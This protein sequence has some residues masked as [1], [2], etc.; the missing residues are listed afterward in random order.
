VKIVAWNLNH[1]AARRRIPTWVVSAVESVAP[2]VAIFTEYVEGQDH[3]RFLADLSDIG[4]NHACVSSQ[5]KGQNQVLIAS[6][7]EL[8]RG[9]LLAPPIHPSV[10]PNA[11]HV[12]IASTGINVLGFRMPAFVGSEAK[13]LK[14]QT[15]EWIFKVADALHGAPAIIAG[16][17]NTAVE[18]GMSYCGDCISQLISKGW[19]HARPA[20]GCSFRH[21]SGSER[22]I[23]HAFLS[24]ELL[25]VASEYSWAFQ[26]LSTEAKSARVGVPDHAMHI[27]E[28]TRCA[29][30]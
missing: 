12:L 13:M 17:F 28:C 4:L 5:V 3:D 24:P 15:W 22:V 21:N 7:S 1:R 30:K 9:G 6:R 18:D 27:V 29:A 11:L 25:L 10:P 26:E 16:D 14:R 2:D 20:V 8:V 19:S 23:D